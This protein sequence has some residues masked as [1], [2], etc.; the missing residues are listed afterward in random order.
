MQLIWTNGP[1]LPILN[2]APQADISPIDFASSVFSYKFL[3]K[4]NPDKF[5]FIS[6]IP[7]PSASYE[8]N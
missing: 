6:G 1:S 4:L 8:M 3:L 5:D 7:D 2:P